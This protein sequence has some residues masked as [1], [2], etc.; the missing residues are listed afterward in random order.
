MIKLTP[1]QKIALETELK[2]AKDALNRNRLCVILGHDE[3]LSINELAKA[4]RI[5]PSTVCNY[6]EQGNLMRKI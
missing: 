5:S 4:L 2:K 6:L 3:G 1:D